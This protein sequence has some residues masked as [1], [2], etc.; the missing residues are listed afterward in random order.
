MLGLRK[1]LLI[2]NYHRVLS[3]PDPLRENEITAQDFTMQLGMLGRYFNVL[4][5]GEAVTRLANGALPRRA[6]AVTFDDGYADNVTV[7]LPI[8]QRLG[9]PAAFFITVGFLDGGRMWNDTIT[10]AIGATTGPSLDLRDLGA[11][12]FDVS[13]VEARRKTLASLLATWKYLPPPQRDAH[14]AELARRVN[15]SLAPSAMMTT[16][17]LLRL[18]RAGMEVGA[19]TL[20][21]P[22][23]ARVPSAEARHEI[24][25]SKLELQKITGREI[26]GFAYPNGRPGRDFNDEHVRMVADAGYRFAVTTEYAAAARAVNPLLL[27]RIGTWDR[28]R[29]RFLARLLRFF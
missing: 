20:R 24:T 10:D 2:V 7:A 23:L 27:P 15:G 12:V 8:M 19:H 17:Q 28:G 13:T 29:A 16:E 21:H 5:L 1:R 6:V 4:P 3:V 22:I 14:V 11:E 25:A 9:V 26:A 18:A